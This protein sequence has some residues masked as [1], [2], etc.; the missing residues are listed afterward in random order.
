MF[1]LHHVIQLGLALIGVGVFF[2]LK[3]F[4]SWQDSD[5]PEP[6]KEW[7]K[8]ATP[9]KRIIAATLGFFLIAAGGWLIHNFGL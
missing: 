9:T 1:R 7:T 3:A 5:T 6:Y 8:P 4:Y 2:C